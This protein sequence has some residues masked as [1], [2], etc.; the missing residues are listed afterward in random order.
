MRIHLL[1]DLHLEHRSRAQLD[2]F[3][4]ELNALKARDPADL[5]VLAGD[6]C[7]VAGYEARAAKWLAQM[8]SYYTHTIFVTG[9]HEYSYGDFKSVDRFMAKL[10][11]P[12]LS[13]LS[14][15]ETLTFRG[16]TFY[17]GTMWFPECNKPSRKSFYDYQVIRNFE[18]EVYR[19][20]EKF[21]AGLPLLKPGTVVISHHSPHP[22]S[23]PVEFAAS[24]VNRFFCYDV[25]PHLRA[26]PFAWLHGHTHAPFRYEVYGMQVH[27]NPFGYPGEGA[28]PFFWKRCGIDIPDQSDKVTT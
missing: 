10:S 4:A 7:Q 24:T 2:D 20:H 13:I 21:I 28:N 18:P 23:I 12:N 27:C 3:D 11:I 25:T 16:A 6:I 9:N 15:G 5:L 14:D 1:S 22:R 26:A 17:G 8:A 19:R